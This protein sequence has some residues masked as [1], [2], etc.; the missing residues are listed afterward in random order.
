MVYLPHQVNLSYCGRGSG[1]GAGTGATSG[2]LQDFLAHVDDPE[3]VPEL[4]EA[5]QLGVALL[6]GH[7]LF[8]GQLPAEVFHQLALRRHR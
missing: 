5:V 6:Q 8:A 3:P 1:G 7:L 4:G 2:H